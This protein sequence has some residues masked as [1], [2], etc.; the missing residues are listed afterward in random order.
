MF[1]SRPTIAPPAQTDELDR[2][3][4]QI[5]AQARELLGADYAAVATVDEEGR[6]V[7]QAIVG[8]RSDAWETAAFPVGRGSAGRAVAADRVIVIEDFPDNPDFPPD[9]FPAHSAE[10]MRAALAAPIRGADGRPMGALVA[11]WRTP[12]RV[13]GRRV[14][15]ATTL[16]LPAGLAIENARLVAASA[17][18][19]EAKD[20][21]L[22]MVSHELKT[23]LNAVLGYADLLGLGLEGPLTDGQREMLGRIVSSAR[24]MHSLVGDLLD[25][26]RMESGRLAVHCAPARA[27]DAVAAALTMVGPQAAAK[28]V[29][30]TAGCE[31]PH[32]VWYVGD[33]AR[34]RQVVVNLLSNAVKFTDAGGRVDVVCGHAGQDAGPA[35]CRVPGAGWAYVRVT[36]TG[37]GIPAE[38]LGQ[39]FTPF[40]QLDAGLSRNAGGTGLGLTISR[41]FARLMRG[42]LTVA[43]EVGRGSTFTI[44]LPAAEPPS[45]AA[46]ARRVHDLAGR[47]AGLSALGRRMERQTDAIT[48]AFERRLRADPLVPNRETVTSSQLQDHVGVFLSDI[49]KALVILDEGRAEP[50]LLTDGAEIQRLISELHGAQRCRLGWS[51]AAVRREFEILHEEVAHALAPDAERGALEIVHALVDAAARV[52]VAGFR[53]AAGER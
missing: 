53:R 8:N 16:A 31:V 5:A 12:T 13:E 21:F 3:L 48:D 20:R 37:I 52:S 15:L 14:Q 18:A 27:S 43:S 41:Q 38:S 6:T 30:V 23:P 50:A 11:G 26:A 19:D 25:F 46:D 7:W 29:T 47:V 33:D 22:S 4:D 44:W 17:K 28:R 10:G 9:E 35:G 2:T 45:E 39:V 36:D 24:H 32:D 42:D 40:T 49:A 34:V 1:D 51:E